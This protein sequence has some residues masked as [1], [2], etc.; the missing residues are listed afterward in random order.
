MHHP[1]GEKENFPGGEKE[2]TQ[3]EKTILADQKK[4]KI[5]LEASFV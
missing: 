1:V 5:Y 2:K 3:K 4:G